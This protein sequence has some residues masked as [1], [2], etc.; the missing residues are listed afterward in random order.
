MTTNFYVPPSHLN[1][2]R[3]AL[4]DDE[5]M[6]ASKVLRVRAGDEVTAVDGEGGWY[7]VRLDHVDRRS[8]SGHI[9]ER[10]KN[11]GEP[12]YHLTM[13][14]AVVKKRGRF[15]TF[16]EKAAELG[17]AAVAPLITERTEKE[18]IRHQRAEN[19]LIAAMKQ[20]GRSR[21]VKMSEPIPFDEYLSRETPELG[22]C[23]HE[24]AETDSHI[25]SILQSSPQ[26]RRVHVIVGPE[27]G[28]TD[29]EID[30]AEAAGWKIASLGPRRL[31]AETA[32]IAAAAAVSFVYD[33]A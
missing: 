26:S 20:C 29:A 24:K 2:E 30:R 10:R 8:A 22:I 31:R 3:L 18:G 11:V 33:S 28:L 19:K 17:V 4:P 32:A 7:R 12:T 13:A 16:L 9:I 23:C 14:M 27:G 25:L 15:E 21:L 6:H 5:A 1:G